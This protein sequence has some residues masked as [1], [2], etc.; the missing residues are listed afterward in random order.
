MGCPLFRVKIRLKSC[1]FVAVD[2]LFV[3]GNC[4][5]HF[6]GDKI[7][8]PEYGVDLRRF[9]FEP[10]DDFTTEI[11][12]DDIETKLPVMEP[13]ITVSRV[14]VVG[15]PDTNTYDISLQINVPSLDLEGLTIK[16]Q[17][18]STGYTIL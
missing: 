16:S 8:N 18:N 7:L 12:K 17:L 10:V 11:I 9:I 15:D 13:R 2:D 5:N 3:S 1:I 4:L 6:S 14:Q